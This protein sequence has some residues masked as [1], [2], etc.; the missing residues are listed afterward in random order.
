MVFMRPCILRCASSS[1]PPALLR[2]SASARRPF[3]G[4]LGLGLGLGIPLIP[5]RLS[6]IRDR[7][8]DRS[9]VLVR[10]T[11][12]V[13]ALRDDVLDRELDL[14]LDPDL[15]VVVLLF[16]EDALPL[17]RRPLPGLGLDLDDRSGWEDGGGTSSNSS[18]SPNPEDAVNGLSLWW[19]KETARE[20]SGEE[21]GR[22][23]RG[24]R[25]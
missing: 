21:E 18:D 6:L 20:E 14:D 16:L 9:R 15:V 22:E 13:L 4:P 3:G 10:D 24:R 8:C 2:L 25:E 19:A 7:E 11:G 12:G 1:F 17:G 23:V 5:L